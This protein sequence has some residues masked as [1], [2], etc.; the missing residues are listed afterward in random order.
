MT[1]QLPQQGILLGGSGNSETIP[2]KNW[3]DFSANT[4]ERLKASK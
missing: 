2:W 4:L 1:E 3:S